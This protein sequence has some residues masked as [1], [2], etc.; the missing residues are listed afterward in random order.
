M[1]VAIGSVEDS[2][3]KNQKYVSFNNFSTDGT[4]TFS[5]FRYGP[6]S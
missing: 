2:N 6:R 3:P 4:V 5:E 1:A